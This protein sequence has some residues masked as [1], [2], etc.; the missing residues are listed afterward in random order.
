M[1]EYRV[2]IEERFMR[3]DVVKANSLAEAE[4]IARRKFRRNMYKMT[5]ENL[6]EQ[7]MEVIEEDTGDTTGIFHI[8]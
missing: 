3:E 5:G 6:V 7:T 8:K 1:A 4:S 2:R